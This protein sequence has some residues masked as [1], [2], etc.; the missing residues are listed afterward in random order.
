MLPNAQVALKSP[1]APRPGAGLQGCYASPMGH[2]HAAGPKGH[3][4]AAGP[5]GGGPSPAVGV[6][7]TLVVTALVVTALVVTA[8]VDTAE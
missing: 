6:F 2:Q 5:A 3:Q 4:H 1:G 7:T 8:P